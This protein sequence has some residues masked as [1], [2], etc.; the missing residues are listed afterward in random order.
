MGAVALSAKTAW[1]LRVRLPLVFDSFGVANVSYTG[2][3]VL[4]GGDF[5]GD[6]LVTGPDFNILRLAFPGFAVVPDITGDGIVNS[7]D[8]NI[9]R[10][11][12]LT[13]G[14]PL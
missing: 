12:W 4:P 1:N 10:L 2:D 13:A 9:L 11:N 6:N 3:Q 14:D 7:P 5:N 8:F